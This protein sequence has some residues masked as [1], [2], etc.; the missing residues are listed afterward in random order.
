MRT[1]PPKEKVFA[2]RA[3]SDEDEAYYL[4]NYP[5][6]P[7]KER[8][9]YYRDGVS[10]LSEAGFLHFLPFLVEC[11]EESPYSYDTLDYCVEGQLDDLSPEAQIEYKDLIEK[12]GGKNV[13]SISKKTSFIL[14]GDIRGQSK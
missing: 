3:D 7:D 1:P 13:G 10:F 9:C 5:G 14:A 8:L 6:M 2:G 11:L 4:R 12:H